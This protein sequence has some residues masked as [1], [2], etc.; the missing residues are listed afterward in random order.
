MNPLPP[1]LGAPASLFLAV[2]LSLPVAVAAPAMPQDR[3]G[4]ERYRQAQNEASNQAYQAGDYARCRAIE[5][6]MLAAARRF[7]DRKEEA[8]SIYGL[9]LVATAS[10]QPAEAERKFR[11]SIALWQSIG[12]QKGLALAL[13][14]LGRVLEG[15]GRLPEATEVQVT[16]LELLLKFGTAMDQSES[17]Y[18]LARLFTNLENFPA[19]RH[20]VDR[21]IELMGKT[22]PDFPLGLNLALRSAV[23]RELGDLA[24]ARRDGEQA[25]AAFRRADSKVGTAIGQLALGHALALAGEVEQALALLRSAERTAVELNE[26][27][28]RSDVLL[29]QGQVLVREK[30][31]QPALVA[32]DAAL[33]IADDLSLDQLRR[34]VQLERE[35][36]LS[37]LGRVGEALLASKQAFEAHKRLARLDQIGQMA[38]RSAESQL[39]AINSRFL[40]L[41]PA[42]RAS[43]PVLAPTAPT[44]PASISRWWWWLAALPALGLALALR[45]LRRLRHEKEGLRRR[46]HELESAHEALQSHSARLQQQVSLD[47]LT[48]VLSRR[49]FAE[50]LSAL[51][52]F[53]QGN[54][55]T[56]SLMLFDLD[57]FK[58]INDRHGHLTGDAALRFLVGL[59]RE[60]LDSDDLC[61]RFGGDEFLIASRESPAAVL[62]MAERIR[63]SVQ[64]RSRAADSGL[65]VLGISVGLA[66]AD[67]AAGYDAEELFLRADAAL[68]NAKAAGRNRVVVGGGA[69]PASSDPRSLLHPVT[70]PI[71]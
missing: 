69:A 43:S 59:V 27:V 15:A 55:G 22:P 7:G 58:Q 19:A 35:K 45:H 11:E 67:P 20:G 14:G 49:A 29:A 50:E 28:L 3:A 65:P 33:A 21:A 40:A 16:G 36:A 63:V 46:Q 39:A 13:R 38:G 25:L 48:G 1:R 12:D 57:H 4:Y 56:V 30:R 70:D 52:A 44:P 10:G 8:M 5:D 54:G 6:A 42:V 37:A 47:P 24:A 31:Y 23:S 68:Y 66:H 18:S 32:L 64:S 62:A 61:G 9:G 53:A 60:Q 51:L 41:D 71:D 34:N 17:Y 26:V 2:C